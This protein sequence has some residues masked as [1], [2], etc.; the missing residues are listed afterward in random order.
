MLFNRR[1]RPPSPNISLLLLI[2]VDAS[3]QQRKKNEVM[4]G[5]SYDIPG[6]VVIEAAK[7]AVTRL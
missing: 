2:T 6:A 4:C 5:G 3:E 7:I 1:P